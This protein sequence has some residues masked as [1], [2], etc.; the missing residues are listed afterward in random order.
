[1][2][3]QGIY[4][5]VDK[6]DDTHGKIHLWSVSWFADYQKEIVYTRLGC[7]LLYCNKLILEIFLNCFTLQ[8]YICLISL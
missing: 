4:D 6:L 5:A 2:A 7:F 3:S 8:T 1:M